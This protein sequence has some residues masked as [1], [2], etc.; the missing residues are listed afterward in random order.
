MDIR[1]GTL[2]FALATEHPELLAKPVSEALATL[3]NSDTVGVAEI[4][5][6][7]SDTASFCEHY[8]IKPDE[9]A[10]CVVIETKGGGPAVAK[11]MAGK[12]R[13]L[14]A[15]VILSNTR[16]DVNG[17]VCDTLGVRKASFAQMEKA[18]SE[19]GMEYGAITPVG[20]PNE[21]PILID[22]RVADTKL[23]VIGSGIRGSKLVVSGSL[24]ASLPNAQVVESLANPRDVA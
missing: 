7:L 17:A 16:A 5:P 10:N 6:K 2:D 20:L 22:R 8:K 21:W 12:E 13:K 24:L 18:V 4:D 19:S 11:A 23:V 3:A 9:A 14:A 1:L 15:V